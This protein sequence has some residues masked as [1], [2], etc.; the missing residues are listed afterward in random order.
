MLRSAQD[1]NVDCR[2]GWTSVGK[3][4]ES[5]IS[6][7][8]PSQ[9]IDVE[10]EYSTLADVIDDKDCPIPTPDVESHTRHRMPRIRRTSH[11]SR[12]SSGCDAD[13]M[14]NGEFGSLMKAYR[15]RKYCAEK[16]CVDMAE[17]FQQET[18]IENP[19]IEH[20]NKKNIE[21]YGKQ[22]FDPYNT[23]MATVMIVNAKK[24]T[25]K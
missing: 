11:Q 18:V 20:R 8:S 4:N 15:K 3:G 16:C 23:N 19:V 1:T 21:F 14:S 12:M 24:N 6:K 17:P 5:N 22:Y 2:G 10:N 25:L 7:A 13:S 9:A